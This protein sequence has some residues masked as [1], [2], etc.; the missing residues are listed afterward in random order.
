[1]SLNC[2]D[3]ISIPSLSD[4][5]C[6][7]GIFHSTSCIVNQASIVALNL[8]ANSLLSTIISALVAA[9]VSNRALIDSLT[10]RIEALEG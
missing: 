10:A 9:D 6:S 1:M 7:D 3:G 2:N 5:P 8:P 4:T